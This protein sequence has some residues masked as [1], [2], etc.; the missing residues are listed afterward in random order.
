M[1]LNV[2]AIEGKF[3]STKDGKCAEASGGMVASAHSLAS[4]A[5]AEMLRQ[6]GNAVDAA[7]ATAFALGVAEP[8]ASGLGGQ[9]MALVHI[10]G[11]TIAFDGSGRVPS[12]GHRDSFKPSDLYLGRR[13]AAV[14][15][16]PAFLGRLH[17]EYGRLPWK[18]ILEPAISIAKNG[19]NITGLQHMLQARE[20]EKFLSPPAASGAAYFLKN[21][22]EPYAPGELFTQPDLAQTLEIIS[23][24]GVEDFYNGE[25]AD[26]IDRD[27]RKHDGFLRREDLAYIPW[28]RAHKPL[29]VEISGL[30]IA[31]PPPPSPG[32]SLIGMLRVIKS[33]MG[34]LVECN[35]SERARM[36]VELI[37]RTLLFQK[38]NP[39]R[40]DMYNPSGD[41]MVAGETWLNE[42]IDAVA[43]RRGPD[44]TEPAY[45]GGE[46]THLSVMDGSGNAAG[47]TQSVNL[48]YGSKAA[49]EGLGF[50]YNN[51]LVDQDT[52]NPD[53]PHF[54]RPNAVPVSMVCPTLVFHN[55]KP[56]IMVGSPGSDRILSTVLQFLVHL[57][58]DDASMAEAMEAPRLHCSSEGVLSYEAER[59]SDEIR[60]ELDNSGFKVIHQEPYSFFHGAIHA[61]MMRQTGPGFQG[62]AEIRRD[63]TAVGI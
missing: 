23:R 7:C 8:Q 50:L 60:N 49:A 1:K 46:T 32:R 22:V 52:Q 18:Q 25:I 31:A 13:A 28:P 16:T 29:F 33:L 61:V 24:K 40:P 55:K 54:L 42:M 26:A 4:E 20:M 57:I 2:K 41:P 19:Y 5:G 3:K 59:F 43:V 53:H 17:K 21:G 9:S 11:E 15:S 58:L 37:Y 48:V 62:V 35:Q 38:K 47:V 56:W 63:G 34:R 36:M 14:P 39:S 44:L 10:N 51:Y 30:N 27:M 45:A 12:L 6:G